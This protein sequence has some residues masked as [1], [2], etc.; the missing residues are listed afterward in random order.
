[1]CAPYRW[2]MVLSTLRTIKSCNTRGVPD[3]EAPQVKWLHSGVWNQTGFKSWLGRYYSYDL[4]KILKLKCCLIKYRKNN[5]RERSCEE[6]MLWKAVSRQDGASQTSRRRWWCWGLNVSPLPAPGRGDELEKFPRRQRQ[7]LW[8]PVQGVEGGELMSFMGA[9]CKA[10]GGGPWAPDARPALPTFAPARCG[11]PGC[12]GPDPSRERIRTVGGPGLL[13]PPGT[14]KGQRAGGLPDAV[15][16]LHTCRAHLVREGEAP[17]RRLGW[18]RWTSSLAPSLYSKRPRSRAFFL[19]R[20]P[21]VSHNLPGHR[22]SRRG[23]GSQE[24]SLRL[25]STPRA[26]S[27]QTAPRAPS[28]ASS[29]PPRPPPRPLPRP[30][31]F[32]V[33]PGSAPRTRRRLRRLFA[34]CSTAVALLTPWLH[35]AALKRYLTP[36]A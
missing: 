4:T 27:A 28:S 1:M 20:V 32:Q 7:G 18:G 29:A 36:K 31:V 2:V 30:A 16:S 34:G 14:S 25:P 13:L 21:M 5:F 23:V 6:V 17:E 12:L 3:K 19:S 33:P 11:L 8:R 24:T 26:H 15:R 10:Q 35:S 9:A 22:A